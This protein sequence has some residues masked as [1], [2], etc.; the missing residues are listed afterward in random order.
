MGHPLYYFQKSGD[1]FYSFSLEVC[2][3]EPIYP[4]DGYPR[5]L[6]GYDQTLSLWTKWLQLARFL[7]LAFSDVDQRVAMSRQALPLD[8]ILF[9]FC[10]SPFLLTLFRILKWGIQ[11]ESNSVPRQRHSGV[12]RI[13]HNSGNVLSHWNLGWSHQLH[14][15]PCTYF[16]YP[17]SSTVCHQHKQFFLR[18]L[19]PSFLTAMLP[20]SWLSHLCW[21]PEVPLPRPRSTWLDL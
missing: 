10:I 19:H 15:W 20:A 18:T 6:T 9:C 13:N 16:Q 21:T 7:K 2:L 3:Q 8:F 12:P 4:S 5:S 11:E 14:I 17:T 1:F